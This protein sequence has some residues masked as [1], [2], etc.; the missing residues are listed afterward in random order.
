[1][2]VGPLV[3]GVLL[4]TFWWGSA[5]L[6]GVPVMVVLLVV[7][8][9][10]LPE[11]RDTTA[12]RVDL[13]SVGLS[14]GAVL[15]VVYGLK[16][17][18]GHGVTTLGAVPVIAGLVLGAVF[19]RRQLRL[20]SPLLDLRLFR[21]RA[22]AG[23]LGINVGAG[24]V[25]AGTFLLMTLW[26]Q[27]V[28]GLS[29]LHVGLVL[30]PLQAAMVVASLL[31]P[32]LARRIA[33]ARV[34]AAGLLIAAVGL[35]VASR[36]VAEG[37]TLVLLGGFLLASVGIALPTA[38]GTDLLVGAVPAEK[39][40]SAGA[41][42]E[43][44][45]EFG[46]ALGVATLGSLAAVVYRGALVVPAGTPAPV[47]DAAR[48]GI[49]EAVAAGPGPALAEA[50]HSA[51]TAG[52]ATA[53]GLGAV[54]FAGLAVFALVALRPETPVTPAVT[55]EPAVPEPADEAPALAAA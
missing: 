38:L 37:G 36:V 54:V 1:M 43:T 30:A 35:V 34:M 19:A 48:T 29:P 2:T 46:V 47:A 6:L 10:L 3:G 26:L 25:M 50:V 16:Q 21:H 45:G 39:A 27:L 8:P 9:V 40:G 7:G 24:V 42:S 28:A 5:F 17:M 52:L 44:S 41:L 13:L 12:G 22:L 51:F 31:A 49:T 20:A 53:A 15:P 18:A 23:A 4:E 33:P 55:T 11:S 32:R 14:L